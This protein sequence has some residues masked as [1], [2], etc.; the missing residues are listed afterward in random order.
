MLTWA[1]IGSETRAAA[2]RLV[3][4]V[5][6]RDPQAYATLQMARPTEA[7]AAVI[8]VAVEAFAGVAGVGSRVESAELDILLGRFERERPGITRHVTPLLDAFRSVSVRGPSETS[9]LTAIPLF[10]EADATLVAVVFLARL[11]LDAA[12]SSPSPADARFLR[13]A[14]GE[15]LAESMEDGPTLEGLCVLDVAAE[16]IVGTP[17]F[18]S[19][20]TYVE[21]VL[22]SDQLAGVA[23]S[24]THF[25][26]I[27]VDARYV[28]ELHESIRSYK[29]NPDVGPPDAYTR[30]EVLNLDQNRAVR[31][32]FATNPQAV[33]DVTVFFDAESFP[34]AIDLMKETSYLLL[35][36]LLPRESLAEFMGDKERIAERSIGYPV[37]PSALDS[38]S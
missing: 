18:H 7:L 28:P 31:V 22:V 6:P 4:S 29:R 9:R 36:L 8:H 32:S 12:A 13:E 20:G 25:P 10:P 30:V 33:P 1:S 14:F 37:N 11:A 35:G 15:Q 27:A 3:T 19:A 16:D 2:L 17:A 38:L 5:E 21:G 26:L 24:G 34:Q 23:M